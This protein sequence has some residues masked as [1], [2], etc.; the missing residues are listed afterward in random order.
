MG[1]EAFGR[2]ADRGFGHG[3]HRFIDLSDAEATRGRMGMREKDQNR[4]RAAAPV[5]EA[6]M[7]G[8]RVVETH[9]LFDEPQAEDIAI[10]GKVYR[11]VA[12]DGGDVVKSGHGW[13]CGF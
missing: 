8:A 12:G 6:E 1:D 11:R 9:G 3:E 5:A 13:V 7:M 10:E 2:G 4:A